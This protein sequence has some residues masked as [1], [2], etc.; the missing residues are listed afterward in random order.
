MRIV[1]FQKL[2]LNVPHEQRRR[3]LNKM[4]MVEDYK[5]LVWWWWMTTEREAADTLLHCCCP[6][7]FGTTP[8]LAENACIGCIGCV[9]HCDIVKN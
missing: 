2:R 5:D 6:A 7:N 4:T 1:N 8:A 3:E 9:L